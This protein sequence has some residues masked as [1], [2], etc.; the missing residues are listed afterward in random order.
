MMSAPKPRFEPDLIRGSFEAFPQINKMTPGV[1]KDAAA[2]DAQMKSKGK[3][4]PGEQGRGYQHQGGLR[5]AG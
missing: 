4:V 3:S 2:F 1:M 5:Q